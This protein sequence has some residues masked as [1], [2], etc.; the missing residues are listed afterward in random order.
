M[1]VEATDVKERLGYHTWC[2]VLPV[3]YIITREMYDGLKCYY[4]SDNMQ[5]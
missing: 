1:V 3:N 5:L 2:F 4:I